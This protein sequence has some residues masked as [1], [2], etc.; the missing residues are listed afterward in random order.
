MIITKNVQ[1]YNYMT[2]FILCSTDQQVIFIN[3]QYIILKWP[4]TRPCVSIGVSFT[5]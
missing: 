5:S 3:Y 2:N 1:L 4:C